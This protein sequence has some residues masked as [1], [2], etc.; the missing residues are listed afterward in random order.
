VTGALPD[1][2]PRRLSPGDWT[3]RSHILRLGDVPRML[4]S[5]H[6]KLGRC[7]ELDSGRRACFPSGIPP[8]PT[9]S[10]DS[11]GIEPRGRCLQ[12]SAAHLRPARSPG[13]FPATGATTVHPTRELFSA[14][15]VECHAGLVGS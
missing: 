5:P 6:L 15:S 2:S 1:L 9:P 13:G 12:G 14:S 10:V 3:T 8:S 7:V 4:P 11:R